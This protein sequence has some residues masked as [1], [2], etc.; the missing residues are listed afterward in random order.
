MVTVCMATRF[1]IAASSDDAWSISPWTRV[2]S[3]STCRVSPRFLVRRCISSV[4]R[5]R[6][7]A[8][9]C[10]AASVSVI[11]APR[12]SPSVLASSILPPRSLAS[13]SARLRNTRIHAGVARRVS[14]AVALSPR[15]ASALAA[16]T[17]HWSVPARSQAS[18]WLSISGR[19]WSAGTARPSL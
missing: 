18:W 3:C 16:I 11:W 14:E 7:A 5:A 13:A 2:I 17:W 4:N 19:T 1:F 8:R 10:W 6:S 15:A 12:S 9:V